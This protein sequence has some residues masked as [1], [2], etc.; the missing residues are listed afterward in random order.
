MKAKN[1]PD[2]FSFFLNFAEQGFTLPIENYDS[3]KAD[4]LT[5]IQLLISSELYF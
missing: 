3:I 5:P 4:C 1:G 2:K